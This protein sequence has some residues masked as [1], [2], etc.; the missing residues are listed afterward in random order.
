[1][2]ETALD[3]MAVHSRQDN[4]YEQ[5]LYE[6]RADGR[7]SCQSNSKIMVQHGLCSCQSCGNTLCL[8]NLESMVAITNRLRLRLIVICAAVGGCPSRF[9]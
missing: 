3:G 4:L 5:R 9:H 8:L 1:M 2:L 6:H 7:C